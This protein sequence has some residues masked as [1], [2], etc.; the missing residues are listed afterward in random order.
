MSPIPLLNNAFRPTLPLPSLFGRS[1]KLDMNFEVVVEF[2][3]LV[4]K[5][6]DCG[7]IV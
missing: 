1:G 6:D 3:A 4:V 7:G 5:E 2:G